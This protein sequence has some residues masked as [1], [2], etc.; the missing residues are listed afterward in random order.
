M[1][2]SCPIAIKANVVKN[3]G[4][5][6]DALSQAASNTSAAIMPAA[7]AYAKTAVPVI[8]ASLNA[9]Y[10]KAGTPANICTT[11]ALDAQESTF[12]G[13]CTAALGAHFNMPVAPPGASCPITDTDALTQACRSAFGM[14][15]AASL[16][17]PNGSLCAKE[18]ATADACGKPQTFTGDGTDITIIL[19]QPCFSFKLPPGWRNVGGPRPP[20]LRPANAPVNLFPFKVPVSIVVNLLPPVVPGGSGTTSGTKPPPKLTPTTIKPGGIIKPFPIP[21]TG[22]S[23]GGAGKPTQASTG[24]RSTGGGTN[25]IEGGS[26]NS[27]TVKGS[28]SG[29]RSNPMDQL[30]GQMSGTGIAN[31]TGNAGGAG[32][33][34]AIHPRPLPLPGGLGPRPTGVVVANPKGGGTGGTNGNS[35]S[36]G[37]PRPPGQNAGGPR[38]PI[39]P[40]PKAPASP[41]ADQQIDYGG[42]SANCGQPRGP[43]VK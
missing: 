14:S 35:G 21:V 4:Q 3:C 43:V 12:V 2:E 27:P 40:R 30:Q 36:G 16:A 37:A 10:Q 5:V 31:V 13:K 33:G 26:G 38:P 1:Y 42:C 6:A 22:N 18:E 11:D 20:F 24:N 25:W 9:K 19:P 34:P 39:L 41:P 8:A 15:E 7:W 29:G 23:S 28:S 32:F 17:G